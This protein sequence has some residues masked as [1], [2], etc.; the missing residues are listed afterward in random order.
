MSPIEVRLTVD[1]LERLANG[2]DVTRDGYAA[3]T[4]WVEAV[5]VVPP[6]PRW[7]C[8]RC[9][10]TLTPSSGQWDIRDQ[11]IHAEST[12]EARRCGRPVLPEDWKAMAHAWRDKYGSGRRY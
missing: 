6:R 10:Q 5:L 7:S 2:L 9:G 1:E 3:G 4:E 12:D 11:W 8:Q